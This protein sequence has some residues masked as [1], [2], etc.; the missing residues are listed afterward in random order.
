MIKNILIVFA[1]LMIAL[2]LGE[3]LIRY[4]AYSLPIDITGVPTDISS[5]GYTLNPSHGTGR[6]QVANRVTYY[7]Y[8]FPHLR[9]TPIDSQAVPILVLG[10]SFTFG[11]LLSANNT[12]LYHLQKFTDQAFGQH[13]YQFLNAA[14]GG[15]GTADYLAYLEE[16]GEQI[17]PKMIIVFLNTDDI[18][19]SFKR[20][21]YV[22]DPKHPRILT[23]HFHPVPNEKIKRW[24]YDSSLF[25]QSMLLHFLRYEFSTLINRHT[26]QLVNVAKTGY[27]TIP[28]SQDLQA[29]KTES[30]NLGDALFNRLND[31]CKSHQAKLV[32]ITT[33]FNAFYPANAQDP[34]YY[35]MTDAARYFYANKIAYKEN[36]ADLKSAVAGKNIQLPND[37]HPNEEGAFIIAKISWPFIK[38]QIANLSK[39]E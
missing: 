4:A 1:S 5:R 16:F 2:L 22:L 31:W 17:N 34:T 35:F 37:Q 12:Y 32:V 7:Q 19:R 30:I 9:D 20:N 14:T 36:A 18:G 24:I 33:G 3:G 11:W 10:D 39:H 26:N 15:W 25:K 21:I 23:N 29:S 8:Y 13:N 38:N 28:V 27:Y 6:H